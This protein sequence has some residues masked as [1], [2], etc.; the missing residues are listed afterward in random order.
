MA[1]NTRE[2]MSPEISKFI[3]NKFPTLTRFEQDRYLMVINDINA[4]IADFSKRKAIL[5]EEFV[6]LADA[7]VIDPK[8]VFAVSNVEPTYPSAEAAQLAVVAEKLSEASRLSILRTA[9]SLITEYFVAFAAPG[10]EEKQLSEKY[11][12]AS[13]FTVDFETDQFVSLTNN[14]YFDNS[15]YNK[16]YN[17]VRRKYPRS[18]YLHTDLK[19]H[20]LFVMRYGPVVRN[21]FKPTI[22]LSSLPV[23]C[24][25]LQVSPHWLLG[26]TDT[27][28]LLSN[29]TYVDSIVDAYLL[30]PPTTKDALYRAASMKLAEEGEL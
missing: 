27:T 25:N 7:G 4:T 16:I 8:E 14:D 3:L 1:V 30:M 21:K 11:G 15:F 6:A 22:E 9:R 12:R 20:I 19:D 17:I 23:I 2:R 13:H 26:L 18:A 28:C 24:S 5:L 29:V 10:S